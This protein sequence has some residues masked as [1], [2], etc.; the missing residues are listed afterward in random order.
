MQELKEQREVYE[1]RISELEAES[2]T[3]F[4]RNRDSVGSDVDRVMDNVEIIRLRRL[5]K[6]QSAQIITLSDHIDAAEKE[7]AL[8]RKTV[9]NLNRE[10]GKEFKIEIFFMFSFC[11][12]R[13]AL[14][15][16]LCE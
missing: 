16:V 9:E 15:F 11:K 8:L 12:Q 3:T 7:L 14:S 5:N 2:S 13:G 10:T 1:R 4:Q 6:R